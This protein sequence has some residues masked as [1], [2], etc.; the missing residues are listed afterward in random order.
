MVK[1]IGLDVHDKMTMACVLDPANG[2][3]RLQQLASEPKAIRE[4]LLQETAGRCRVSFE[5]GSRAGLLYDQLVGRV[6]KVTVLNGS[7]MGPL[8][9]L[10]GSKTDRRDAQVM[11]ETE[12]MGKSPAVWMPSKSVRDWRAMIQHRRQ[13][14]ER[15]TRV[16]NEIRFLLKGQGVAKPH[17]GGWWSKKSLDWM[18]GLTA[19]GSEL[20]L[21]QL[22]DLLAELSSLN[23]RIKAASE[24]LDQR[25]EGEP[26]VALLRTIPGV[27]PRTAEVVV[28]WLDD[29]RRFSRSRTVGKY[30]GLT[31]RLDESA[32]KARKGHITKQGPSV[33]R[34]LLVEAAWRVIRV[35]AA[36]KGFYLRVRGEDKRRTKIAVVAVARKL[37]TIMAAMLRDGTCWQAAHG[38]KM[39]LATLANKRD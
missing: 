16:K 5:V 35:N 28:A 6:Q 7:K 24:R 37:A 13:M 39:M 32:G 25:G 2:G 19:G 12:A 33:V 26:G 38:S 3:T 29:I 21:G 20:W 11:A 30:F 10:D 1:C 22:E 34:W 27:G 18:K 8:Y 9:R 36:L 31:P 4:W 15:R 17:R 23:E 14:I